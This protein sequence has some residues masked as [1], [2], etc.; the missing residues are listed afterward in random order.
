MVKSIHNKSYSSHGSRG[1][2]VQRLTSAN[3]TEDEKFI[4]AYLDQKRERKALFDQ[5]GL[6]G[7]DIDDDEFEAYLDGLGGKKSGKTEVDVD[8]DEEFDFLGDF[9]DGSTEKTTKGKKSKEDEGDADWDSDDGEDDGVD[10][11]DGDDD[12]DMG[13]GKVSLL[14]L[15]CIAKRSLNILCLFL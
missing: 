5:A 13:A 14:T 9:N 10:G 15:R 11:D 2:A 12:D 3:C 8:D 6:D 7:D 1:Q 4:F